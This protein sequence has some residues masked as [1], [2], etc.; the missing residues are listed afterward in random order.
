MTA[1]AGQWVQVHQI[2]LGPSERAAQVPDDTKL[3]PLEMWV[4]GYLQQDA[5]IGEV[6]EI[7][8]VTGRLIQGTLTEIEPGYTH[9]FGGYV[10]ELGVVREQVRALLTQE[11]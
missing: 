1:K 11:S 6:C 4:K 2:V 5:D 3:V 10:E 8:T 9:G 7:K